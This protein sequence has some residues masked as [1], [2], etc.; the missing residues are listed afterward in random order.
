MAAN[1][2]YHS[3]S[4]GSERIEKEMHVCMYAAG[5]TSPTYLC[6]KQACSR[7]ASRNSRKNYKHERR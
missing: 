2:T 3:T 4:S 5:G 1:L 7:S 6:S